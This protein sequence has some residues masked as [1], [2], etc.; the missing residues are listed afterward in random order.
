MAVPSKDDIEAASDVVLDGAYCTAVEHFFNPGARDLIGR[1]LPGFLDGLV[2]TPT[3]LVHSA[4][5]QK[6]LHDAGRTMMNAVDKIATLQARRKNESS[7]KRV[8]DLHALVSAASRK[9]WDDEKERPYP[10]L[11]ADNFSSVFATIK[12]AEAERDY[13]INRALSEYLSQYKVWKDK[14]A[15]LTGMV[16]STVG[17][18]ENHYVEWLLGECL[19]SDPA[20][21]QLFG[22]PDRLEARCNDLVDLWKGEWQQRDTASAALPDISALIAEGAAPNVKAGIEYSLLRTLAGKEPL[23]SAEPEQEIQALFEMFRKMW[24]GSTLIGGQKALALLEK[25][26]ARYINNEGVTDLLRERKVLA[27][28]VAFLMGLSALAIGQGNRATL[29]IFIDH[30]FGDQ[31]FIPRVVSGQDAPVPKLQTFTAT[32]RSLRSSWLSDDDKGTYM[33]LVETAQAELIKRSRLFEQVDK[34]SGSP[35]QKVLTLLDLCRKA[36]FIEGRNLDGVKQSI[37]R[38]L[39]DPQFVPDYLGGSQGEERERKV[40][41]L[42]KTL[43]AFGIRS[44]LG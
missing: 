24:T 9:V 15:V 11:T 30:Y 25:R 22:M 2:I 34:K 16:R 20:L 7:A 23:R 10:A 35:A 33:A 40:Q 29:K 17:R 21:D 38:Y 28:R 1:F 32:H 8:K 13:T 31:D 3:E 18:D 44:S 6:R 39:Q 42:V 12:G 19:R 14:V 37:E 27:D 36:T 41:L 43:A 4:K 26:Q 5:Y